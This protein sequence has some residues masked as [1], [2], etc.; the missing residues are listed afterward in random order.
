[1]IDEAK[2]L[3]KKETTRM[4]AFR[5]RGP[6]WD[7]RIVKVRKTTNERRR[8]REETDR[9]GTG[10]NKEETVTRMEEVTEEA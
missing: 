7:R 9:K 2:Q 10:E 4:W 5:V 6:P 3:E 1:M 8:T